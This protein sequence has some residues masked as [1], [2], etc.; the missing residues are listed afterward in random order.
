MDMK[1]DMDGILILDDWKDPP[2]SS[3]SI[4]FRA[5]NTE[6]TAGKVGKRIAVFAGMGLGGFV[7]RSG[8]GLRTEYPGDTFMKMVKLSVRRAKEDGLKVRICDEDRWPSGG[9]EGLNRC[10]KITGKN[11]W[12]I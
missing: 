6:I 11:G 4:P 1:N 3:R 12:G 8:N 10:G 2:I 9:A 7:I 5:W